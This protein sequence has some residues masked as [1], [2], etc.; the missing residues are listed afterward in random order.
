MLSKNI[1]ADDVSEEYVDLQIRQDNKQAYA[2]QYRKLLKRAGS[3]KDI[4][5]VQEKLRHIESGIDRINGRLKFLDDRVSY[6]TLDV[7][8]RE[9]MKAWSV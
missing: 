2:V 7:E 6:S 8:L 9:S 4:L 5:E 3:I 1:S